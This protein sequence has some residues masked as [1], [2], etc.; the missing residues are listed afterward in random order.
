MMKAQAG[1]V[2]KVDLNAK[3]PDGTVVVTSR[4]R[5]P[6]SFQLGV[7]EVIRG[8]ENAVIGMTEGESK[9]EKVPPEEAFGRYS[10]KRLIAIDRSEFPSHIEPYR[11]QFLRV[12][13]ANGRTGIVRV[14][15]ADDS[16]VMLDTNHLLAGKEIILEIELLEVL[17]AAGSARSLRL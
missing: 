10:G 7:G 11:G 6:I 3:L 13:R 2:V 14:A 8:L 12:K 16:R 9:T 4:G 15:L 5:E 1:D 17:S